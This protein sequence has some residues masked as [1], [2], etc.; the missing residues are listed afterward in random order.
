MF[1][2]GIPPHQELRI[3]TPRAL[4]RD[5]V[6]REMTYMAKANWMVGYVSRTV[7][8]VHES[9]LQ[10]VTAVNLRDVIHEGQGLG[11]LDPIH[12]VHGSPDGGATGANDG[13]IYSEN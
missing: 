2:E 1:A 12:P 3:S 7:D 10:R 9:T 6:G 5:G 11:S 8:P 4:P 13:R